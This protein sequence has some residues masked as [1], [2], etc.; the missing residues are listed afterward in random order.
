MQGSTEGPGRLAASDVSREVRLSP[1]DSRRALLVMYSGEAK[2]AEEPARAPIERTVNGG[3][4]S[5]V[6]APNGIIRIVG[7]ANNGDWIAEFA[8]R[9]RDFDDRFVRRMERHVERIA[10]RRIA[11]VP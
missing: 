2:R 11:I 9:E 10:G 3:R 8:C 1:H 7:L 5:A 6:P 4:V